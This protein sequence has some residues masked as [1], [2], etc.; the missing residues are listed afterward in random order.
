MAA[1]ATLVGLDLA[2]A[3]LALNRPLDVR[4]VAAEVLDGAQAAGM[5]PAALTAA[6][7]LREAAEAG[8]VTPATVRHVKHF[9]GGWKQSLFSPSSRRRRA[10]ELNQTIVALRTLLSLRAPSQ[11]AGH[12]RQRRAYAK[13]VYWR[14]RVADACHRARI[15]RFG[16]AG[17]RWQLQHPPART[18]R[19]E[20]LRSIAPLVALPVPSSSPYTTPSRRS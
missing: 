4:R 17:G 13:C 10:T 3:L 8:T 1:D 15:L 5:L 9:L 19:S 11:C 16:G 18:F 20:L 7:F 6:A 2:E 14:A 12:G